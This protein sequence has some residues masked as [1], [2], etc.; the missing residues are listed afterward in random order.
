MRLRGR[1]S[2][3]CKPGGH[4]TAS[5]SNES[6]GQRAD[7][8]VWQRRSRKVARGGL[9]AKP[10]CRLLLLTGGIRRSIPQAS[11]NGISVRVM[12]R[13]V[14]RGTGADVALG[15]VAAEG[16]MCT[17]ASTIV[18]RIG[19]VSRHVSRSERAESA[20]GA[21]R[22]APVTSSRQGTLGSSASHALIKRANESGGNA[23]RAGSQIG[24][25][26]EVPPPHPV[27][28]LQPR[29]V[30]LRRSIACG[31]TAIKSRQ[32]PSSLITLLCS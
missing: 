9:V 24:N 8:R 2:G 28:M 21:S 22:R 31:H 26:V 27:S 7:I 20:I 29:P 18:P 3:G 11:A 5:G 4:T 16:V 10:S 30:R 12:V 15:G 25:L 14:L 19:M 32:H 17:V 13:R 1:R 23:G 6:G